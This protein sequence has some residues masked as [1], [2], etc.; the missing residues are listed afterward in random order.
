MHC[1]VNLVKRNKKDGSFIKIDDPSFQFPN[2]PNLILSGRFSFDTGNKVPAIPVQL[3]Q[4]SRS[5]HQ[6][7][8]P[9]NQ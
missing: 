5:N 8:Q 3:P 6:V 7:V 2:N 1:K 9:G 4:G